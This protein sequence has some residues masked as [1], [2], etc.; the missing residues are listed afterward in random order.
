MENSIILS[1][2]TWAKPNGQAV[3][4]NI[5]LQFGNLRT[6]LVGRNGV[7]KTTLLKLINGEL[8]PQNGH[9]TSQIKIAKLDQLVTTS[10]NDTI[11][12]LFQATQ[13]LKI[14]S[15]AEQGRATADELDIADWSLESRMVGALAQFDLPV[16]LNHP[17]SQLSGGQQTRAML[18]S[19]LFKQPDFILLDEPTNNLDQQ[20]REAVVNL[21][22]QWQ[23][24]AIIVSH[25]RQLLEHVDAIVELTS[26]GATTYGGNWQIYQQQKAVELNA[27]QHDLNVAEQQ[28]AQIDRKIQQVKQRK[29]H[30]DSTG[31]RNRAKGD[32]PKMLLNAMRNNAE[33]TSGSN[34]QLA[35]RMQAQTQAKAAQARE[36]IEI[37]QPFSVTLVSTGLANAKVI[38]QVENLTGGYQGQNP[39]INNL[40]FSMIGPERVAISGANGSGKTTLIKLITGT[41]NPQ[42]GQIN[43][44]ENYT[45]LDQQVSMLD[46]KLSIVD[47]FHRLNPN[48]KQNH[49]RAVL[50]R[51]L[52]R[53][54]DAL[55][56]VNQLSGGE[57]L[58]AA[59]SCVLGSNTP[60]KLLILDEPTNHLDIDSITTVEAGLNAYD[61]AIL[62]ISHDNIFLEN[63]AI[64]RHI[65]LIK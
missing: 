50:A 8:K 38:L 25:D 44:I 40:S 24:G 26:L 61:G 14:L 43:L 10:K 42:S 35:S 23:G 28:Q 48:A 15:R 62:L 58:R 13:A 63:I 18:A 5:N 2:I 53:A 21:L 9:I 33:Q 56:M 4:S 52:F 31:K 34:A 20:G 41:L 30:K 64:T 11:A 46:P 55:K 36:Q 1:N 17:L 49:A 12:D 16:T 39:I 60:P 22:A 37:L 54:D 6:G 51:F 19:L 59:L 27:A 7:G 65:E 47:N 3:F 32:Q 45:L 29:A 57:K